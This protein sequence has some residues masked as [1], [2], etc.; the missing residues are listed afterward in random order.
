MRCRGRVEAARLL[1]ARLRNLAANSRKRRRARVATGGR[2]PDVRHSAGNLISASRPRQR[3]GVEGGRGGACL[4]RVDSRGVKCINSAKPEGSRGALARFACPAARDHWGGV[5][6]ATVE[7][8]QVWKRFG[9]VVAVEDFSLTTSDGELVV[10]VGPS[11][12]G[13]TTTMRIIAGLEVASEG[14]VL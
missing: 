14:K 11:G 1:L 12:C 6:M 10:F 4:F 9:A 8:R 7:L 13:K 2:L 3:R 5:R